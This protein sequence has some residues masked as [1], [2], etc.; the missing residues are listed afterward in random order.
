MDQPT[1]TPK[2]SPGAP[3]GNTNAL[4]HGFYSRA[5]RKAEQTDLS[6]LDF[7]S[8]EY[9]IQLLRV[10]IRR[11]S[12][13]NKETTPAESLVLLNVLSRA[14]LSVGSLIRTQRAALLVQ[15]HDELE[16][17]FAQAHNE[18]ERARE[19]ISRCDSYL[20]DLEA[21]Q[22]DD[23][24]EDDDQEEEDD[25]DDGDED[26]DDEEDEEAEEDEAETAPPQAEIQYSLDAEHFSPMPLR[27]LDT[28]LT[29]VQGAGSG[30]RGGCDVPTDCVPCPDHLTCPDCPV[31]LKEF[32]TKNPTAAALIDPNCSANSIPASRRSPVGAGSQPAQR[33][34][35]TANA[36]GDPP[37]GARR[38]FDHRQSTKSQRAG[39]RSRFATL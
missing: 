1:E 8:L 35:S 3:K 19:L 6:T 22:A 20:A 37:V 26:E 9:E 14:A 27:T 36:Q 13:E 7:S 5:F 2:K 12:E 23:E 30:A 21:S 29:G 33:Q 24:D 15:Q 17:L 25:E 4:K 16:L 38:C 10:F 28:T 18:F 39:S 11:T 34:S 31:E 32:L